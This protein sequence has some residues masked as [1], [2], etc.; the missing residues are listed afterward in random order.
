MP[1]NN[2]Y[3]SMWHI[4]FFAKRVWAI[5]GSFGHFCTTLKTILLVVYMSC[6]Y[7]FRHLMF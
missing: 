7:F 3:L 2:D 4:S 6:N 5:L 1:P